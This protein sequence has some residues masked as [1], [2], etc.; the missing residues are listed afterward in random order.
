MGRNVRRGGN[1]GGVNDGQ[2]RAAQDW[3]VNRT[4]MYVRS[5]PSCQGVEADKSTW[6]RSGKDSST[7]MD[8]VNT[9]PHI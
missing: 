8:W 7:T 3:G 6:G 4:T 1:S 5:A 2:G 9:A